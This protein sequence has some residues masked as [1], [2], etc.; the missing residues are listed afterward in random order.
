MKTPTQS[1]ENPNQANANEWSPP[2]V[3]DAFKTTIGSS[4]IDQF[5][6]GHSLSDVLRE[7]VQNEFD[8]GGNSLDIQFSNSALTVSGSGKPISADGWLRLSAVL[9]TGRRI[10]EPDNSIEIPAKE[11]GIGSKNFGLRSLFLIGDRIFIRSNGKMAILDLP[12]VGSQELT[13]EDSR[14]A[15][16]VRIHVPFRETAFHDIHP[17]T[18]ERESDAFARLPDELLST[19]T[20]L[21]LPGRKRGI[22]RLDIR[23]ERTGQSLAWRQSAK[24]EKCKLK[25][26][27]C[28]HRVG[29][30]IRTKGTDVPKERQKFGEYEFTRLVEV[31]PEFEAEKFPP[32]YRSGLNAKVSVSVPVRG[33]SIDRNA[34][35]AFYYP[36][37]AGDTHTGNGV[38]VSAPFSLDADRSNLIESDWNTWLMNEAGR[39]VCDLLVGDWYER[40]GADAF[41]VIDPGHGNPPTFVESIRDKLKSEACWPSRERNGKR[42]TFEII[43]NIVVPN[44]LSLD[45]FVDDCF[46]L[47]D[48][49]AKNPRAK[50]MAL[51]F[52]AKKYSVNSLVTLRCAASS[53][54][55]LSTRIPDEQAKHY[56]V[57]YEEA[58]SDEE[59]Q[60]KMAEALSQ[61]RL[62]NE[63]R[64][65]LK[66]TQSTL[67]A[68]GSLRTA[69]DLYRI[70]PE[71]WDACPIPPRR[72]LHRRLI[73]HKAISQLCS[74][75]DIERWVRELSD[76]A[77][78]GEI[79]EDER[80]T[81]YEYLLNNGVKIRRNTLAKVKDSPVVKDH[82]GNWI[83]PNELVHISKSNFDVLEPVLHGPA[84][85][86]VRSAEFF[87]RLKIRQKLRSAD[88][89][90]MAEHVSSAQKCAEEFEN[91]LSRH[92]DLLKR[93]TIAKL[94]EIPFM[95]SRAETLAKPTD[96]HLANALNEACLDDPTILLRSGNTT[97]YRKLGCRETPSLDALISEVARRRDVNQAPSEISHFYS[98]LVDAMR[99][100]NQDLT[101]YELDEILWVDGGYRSPWSTVVGSQ[102]PKYFSNAV[103]HYKGRQT[104]EKSYASLGA[105]RKPKDHHWEELLLW[106]SHCCP[107]G[108]EVLD[109]SKQRWLK[110]AYQQ[111]G[112]GGLPIDLSDHARCLLS[113]AG[114]LH[115]LRELEDGLFLEN[116]YPEL[117]AAL[118]EAGGRMAF[119]DVTQKTSAFYKRLGLRRLSAV[120]GKHTYRFGSTFT[121][122]SWFQPKH[123]KSA[124]D[125]I[126]QAEFLNAL[127]ELVWV[128][129]RGHSDFVFE[130]PIVLHERM[131]KLKNI[132][133]VDELQRVHSVGGIAAAI[134]TEVGITEEAIALLKPRSLHDFNQLLSY[135]LAEFVGA[136]SISDIRAFGALVFPLLECR[137]KT[138]M[139]TYLLRQGVTSQSW[140]DE[141]IGDDEAPYD[142]SEE[143]RSIVADVLLDG[144]S[145]GEEVD[146]DHEHQP[147]TSDASTRSSP[148][149]QS[150]VYQPLPAI[151]EVLLEELV[152]S[153][154]QISDF[155]SSKGGGGPG[156][157]NAPTQRDVDRDKQVGDRGEELVYLSELE[158]VR[159]L[160]YDRP[161]DHVVWVSKDD[162][163]ADHDIRSIDKNG[164]PLWI[165]VKS[166]T[167]TDGYFQWPRREFEKALSTGKS[168][169]L[170]RVYRVAT[171]QPVVKRFPNPVS[172]LKRAQLRLRLGEIQAAVEALETDPKG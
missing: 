71:I 96:L 90:D 168:Y 172:L 35:G 44:H 56:F 157:W 81:L 45:G 61:N 66:N 156:N 163:G 160:G 123:S 142:E 39:L 161:E 122:Q 100:E 159:S 52:G 23:S 76:R 8:A 2:V 95:L 119:A 150:K 41:L 115:S 136:T 55:T 38:S 137:T 59:R 33:K 170:W 141:A 25:G 97:L 121:A 91:L 68:D 51:S 15:P 145:A 42:A 144:L 17:F 162:P 63:N 117:A 165:E 29:N 62:S 32:Y 31:P 82:R 153:D 135:G 111:L 60:V 113:S 30:L 110:D 3:E 103:P 128:Y 154:G 34:I 116:D 79:D 112:F 72:R 10:G 133:L 143:H 21:A 120:A 132:E 80:E 125:R 138:D 149:T 98:A 124:L 94:R 126:R 14:D 147:S 166:T 99:L 7:L 167:G 155:T 171:K 129:H 46:Y 88:L 74:P 87:K 89:I 36:L 53:D 146:D 148:S 131:S 67:A 92:L 49:F 105:S 57:E 5:V 86:L 104:I 164:R 114:T 73:D 26:V 6:S 24:T 84:K 102:I 139:R 158:R 11:N 13:D 27:S 152:V 108:G 22:G 43:E 118:S 127:I 130:D 64:Y 134:D 37:A 151:D 75:F 169:E 48:S 83:S 20:K 4:V 93:P 16:G 77:A 70:E 50:E 18:F 65:D 109:R 101:D 54:S 58:L 28:V 85:E 40:F 106:F 19:L 107:T 12:K 9:G 69:N 140:L 47:D 78:E 1:A